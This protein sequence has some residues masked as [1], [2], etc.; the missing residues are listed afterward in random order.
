MSKSMILQFALESRFASYCPKIRLI[1]VL[2][3]IV[4]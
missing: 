4:L 3:Y 1:R 2:G